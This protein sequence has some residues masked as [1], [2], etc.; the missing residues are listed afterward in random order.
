MSYQQ[1]V[2]AKQPSTTAVNGA[3]NGQRFREKRLRL[4]V[5]TQRIVDDAEII[6]R[7]SEIGARGR[8]S[9]A[10]GND[11]TLQQR[12][13]FPGASHL[14]KDPPVQVVRRRDVRRILAEDAAPNGKGLASEWLGA[15]QARVYPLHLITTQPPD[16][17]H[18]QADYGP[19]ARAAKR[20]GHERIRLSTADAGMRSLADGMVVRVFNA[21]G[22][23][24]A[25]VEVDRGLRTGVAIMSTG[26]WYDPAD[27]TDRALERHGNPNV[28]SLD[29]GTSKLSQGPSALS[30][31]VDVERWHGD[32]A[33]SAH[34]PPRILTSVG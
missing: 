22:A 4:C 15:S 34:T 8:P 26:A 10:S 29:Q 19:L 11:G 24:L 9:G 13:G 6:E 21:R 23:C 28:L 33:A 17:L 1:R 3:S 18:S 16:K 30:M 14:V 20:A 25:T 7:P 31:L 32:H 12:L 27:A 2:F 5:T